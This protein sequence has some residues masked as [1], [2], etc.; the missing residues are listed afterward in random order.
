MYRVHAKRYLYKRLNLLFVIIYELYY[1]RQEIN[2]I[3]RL[4]LFLFFFS[5]VCS[6]LCVAIASSVFIFHSSKEVHAIFNRKKLKSIPS[7]C[8]NFLQR[9]RGTHIHISPSPPPLAPSPSHSLDCINSIPFKQGT[10]RCIALPLAVRCG[11]SLIIHALCFTGSTVDVSLSVPQVERVASHK[12][13]DG[14]AQVKSSGLDACE[15]R[16]THSYT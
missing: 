7:L 13:T 15:S 4:S 6:L 11:L 1:F 8:V 9:L 2:Y 3:A 14:R 5:F 12:A 16:Y 10:R